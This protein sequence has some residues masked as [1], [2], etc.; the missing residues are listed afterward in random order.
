[1]SPRSSP[2]GNGYL[3]FGIR[4]P[5]RSPARLKIDFVACFRYS[6]NRVAYAEAAHTLAK[7]DRHND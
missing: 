5:E 1:M 6:V 4:E 7:R 2:P 3:G